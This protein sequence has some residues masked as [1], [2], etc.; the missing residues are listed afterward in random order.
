[1]E[2]PDG[3]QIIIGNK[4]DAYPV[5]ANDLLHFIT[6]GGGGWGDPL[7][8][9]PALVGKEISQGLVT[10]DG[11]KAYGVVAND[12]GTVDIGATEAL[13]AK[14]RGERPPL[15]LFNYG[16]DIETLRANCE[17]ET[18]LPAPVQPIWQAMQ[19]AD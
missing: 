17:L 8:R 16:P 4:V 1:V 10:V 3:T 12:N 15:E 6:W 19:A 18:G 9:A 14:M 7:E 5:E 11:A 2:K 13:R